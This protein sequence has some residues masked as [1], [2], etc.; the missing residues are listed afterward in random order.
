M[1]A[2]LRLAQISTIAR[3]QLRRV[4]FS[5]RSFW[6]YLLAF[7]PCFVF[8]A[9]GIE[10]KIEQNRWGAKVTPVGLLESIREGD[11]DASVIERA[12]EPARDFSH[13]GHQGG[14]ETRFRNMTYFDGRERWFLRFESGILQG[15][16]RRPL[17]NFEEDRSIYAAFFQHFFLRLAIFF[18]CLGIFM[19]LFRGEMLDKTLHYWFLL[20][21]KR[22]VLL[23]G[24]YAAGLVAS[25]TIFGVGAAVAFLLMLW[26]Q[27]AAQASAFWESHGLAHLFSYAAAA[28]LACVGYGSL[29][30]AAG[31][32][33][34]NPIIPA[35]VI[36]G[37][38]NINGILPAIF[39]KMSVLYYAQSLCPVPAP[40]EP[41]APLLVRVLASPAE[42][43]SAAVAVL[44]LLAWTA[45]V[46]WAASRAVRRLEID[47]G[48]D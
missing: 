31:L 25:V 38:E 20:P 1:S 46:L 18:G 24:K 26:P 43:A 33:L 48:V 22:E 45:V 2:S 44:G 30:L 3:L 27:D 8:L 47:Y 11:T 12:G 9:R 28:A 19:N 41:E 36:L 29:F 4:F 40:L 13:G 32:L 10:V 37:W 17:L 6:V 35:V 42:P 23:A 7:F 39:Q 34:R 5:K 14:D 21:A 15:I 16:G